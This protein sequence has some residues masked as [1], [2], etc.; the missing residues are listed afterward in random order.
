MAQLGP[1][2]ISYCSLAPVPAVGGHQHLLSSAHL[3]SNP[4]A[5]LLGESFP[6]GSCPVKKWLD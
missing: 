4:S 3:S 2:L 5:L 6:G 1:L